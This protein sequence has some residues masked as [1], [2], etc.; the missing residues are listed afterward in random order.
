METI[1]EHLKRVRKVCGYSLEDV[2]RVTKIN[3][4][5]L[6]AIENDD[7]AK[8][9][10]ETFLKGFLRSYA[11]FL[12]IKEKEIISKLK[13]GKKT[14]PAAHEAY[15]TE[16]HVS[17]SSAGAS[18]RGSEGQSFIQKNM[19]LILPLGVGALALIIIIVLFGGGRDTSTIQSSKE[20][21]VEEITPPAPA[22][23]AEPAEIKSETLVPPGA[24]TGEPVLLKVSAK[25]LTW[26]QVNLDGGEVKEAL[27]RPGEVVLWTGVDK[28][29]VTIGNAGGVDAEVNGKAQE[30]FGKRGEVVRD[31]VVTSAG[32]SRQ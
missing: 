18:D 21:R 6:E 32:I 2:A 25:E 14:E 8:L 27:M 13:S 19:R 3:L 11:R 5:Y 7:F 29:T 30:P 4:L 15:K 16:V 24:G 28:I 23:P 10:G 20:V 26:I 22:A 12:G 9:P 1:G 17:S 31:V